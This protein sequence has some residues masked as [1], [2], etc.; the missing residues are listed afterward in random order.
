M[1]TKV[2]FVWQDG[3]RYNWAW[4]DGLDAALIHLKNDFDIAYFTPDQDEQVREYKPDVVLFW[5]AA[6]DNNAAKI[7]SWPYK[8]CLLFGGGPLNA[9]LV[10]GW[11]M[12]FVESQIDA[13]T[14]QRLKLPFR[15]AFGV[16]EKVFYPMHLP[17]RYKA[18][19]AGTFAAWK[20]HDLFARALG[21]RGVAI[22]IKQDTERWCYE[23]CEQAGVK[24]FEEMSRPAIAEFINASECVLNTA[25]FWGGGQR[26]TLEAM[27]CNVPPIVMSDSPKNAE[28]V[29]ESGFGI[30]CGPNAEEIRQ[31]LIDVRAHQNVGR[32]YIMSKWTSKHYAEALK[33]GIKSL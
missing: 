26:L 27:A 4:G 10:S 2:A 31:A 18:V 25:D 33:E 28:F 8:K 17:K 11:D 9:D 23:V 30:V 29:R 13:D 21:Q 20:R 19:M 12:V 7:L 1:T 15:R 5:G 22:G 3:P 24:V 6:M 16:N 32:S 14:L